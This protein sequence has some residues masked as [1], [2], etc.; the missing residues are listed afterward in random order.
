MAED[1]LIA[2]V[3]QCIGDPETHLLLFNIGHRSWV[4]IVLLDVADALVG[5]ICQVDADRIGRLPFCPETANALL[6]VL[7]SPD[8]SFP[9][10]YNAAFRYN[11][12]VRLGQSNISPKRNSCESSCRRGAVTGAKGGFS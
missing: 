2:D 7:A 8:V 12:V 11:L 5:F 1:Q 9:S 3:L 10:R 4:V 6:P